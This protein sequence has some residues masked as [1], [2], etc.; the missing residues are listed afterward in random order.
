MSIFSAIIPPSAA[1]VEIFSL[2]EM[3]GTRVRQSITSEN[4]SSCMRICRFHELHA[5]GYPQFFQTA[6]GW[7]HTKQSKFFFPSA[8]NITCSTV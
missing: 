5:E 7:R 4:L 2:M 1:E 8:L 3:I 6:N